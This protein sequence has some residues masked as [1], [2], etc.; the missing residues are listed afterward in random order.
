MLSVVGRGA[1]S[2]RAGR[3]GRLDNLTG[4]DSLDVMDEIRLRYGLNPH[5]KPARLLM[6]GGRP[7]LEV[8]NGQPGFVNVLDALNS[9]QLVRELR[10]LTGLPAAASF[11]HVSPAGAALGLPLSPELAASCFAG[12]AELSPLAAAYVRARGADRMSS[13]GDWAAFSDTVDESC[14]RALKREVS[15]GCIAPGYDPA[16]VE[17]LREKKGGGYP[18]LRVDPGYV[19]DATE[20]RQVFGLTL[21]QSRNDVRVGAD[22]LERVVTRDRELTDDARRDMLV[23]AVVLKYTQSNSMCLVYDGQAVG[24][25]AGQ[26]SR[27]HCTRIACAKADK[28]FL[29]MHPGIRGL[30]FR[31]GVSR[32]HKATAIDLYLEDEATGP[33]LAAWR[34]LFETVPER[35]GADEK[36]EWLDR[37]RG[38]VLGSDAFIPFRDN[39][40]RA[41]RSGVRYVVQPG[42]STRDDDVIR[43]ADEYGM[44]M[45]FTG[46]RLFHH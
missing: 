5:Q 23:A 43:A 34:E 42:G 26:Q 15:D 29:R 39:I 12:K 36:R 41:A 40:D 45:A 44:V 7:P 38:A 17:L 4:I 6:P 46:L 32:S 16:A 19:P 8:V 20:T 3:R 13:F 30:R 37:F 31:K 18:M 9:W 1:G 33:E 35:L 21:E 10:E 11:K 28:W 24:V 2:N 22:L 25:G 14:A 27:I